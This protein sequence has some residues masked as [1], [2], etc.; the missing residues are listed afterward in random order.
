MPKESISVSLDIALV[1]ELRNRA[2]ANGQSFS[3]LLREIIEKERNHQWF[4]LIEMI[5][6]EHDGEKP[7]FEFAKEVV[8]LGLKAKEFGFEG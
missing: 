8:E 6:E 4:E 3:E 5:A 2:E 7:L 1:D